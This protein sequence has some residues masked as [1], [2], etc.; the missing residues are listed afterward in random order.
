M[1]RVIFFP[2]LLLF[3][4][5]F[6]KQRKQVISGSS[7]FWAVYDHCANRRI[8]LLIAGKDFFLQLSGFQAHELEKKYSEGVEA[9]E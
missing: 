8:K 3:F 6:R 9:K 2:L 7:V 1:K 5:V 4:F